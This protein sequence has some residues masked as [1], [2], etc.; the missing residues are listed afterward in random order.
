MERFELCLKFEKKHDNLME[1]DWKIN[2]CGLKC[3]HILNKRNDQKQGKGPRFRSWFAWSD[4]EM[5][6]ETDQVPYA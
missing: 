2:D 5:D 6:L 1:K 4:Q 3:E